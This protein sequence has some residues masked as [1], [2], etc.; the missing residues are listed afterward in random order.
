M[1]M[2]RGLRDVEDDAVGGIAASAAGSVIR[3]HRLLVLLILNDK[4]S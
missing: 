3:S 1:R 2:R 4:M